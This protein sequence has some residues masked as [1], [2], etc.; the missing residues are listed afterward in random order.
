M[1]TW[2][3]AFAWL[4]AAW[5]VA[6]VL[7]TLAG[8]STPDPYGGAAALIMVILFGLPGMLILGIAWFVMRVRSRR[9]C[10]LCSQDLK[11][12]VA[13]CKKC[14]F[15]FGRDIIV[16]AGATLP[17]TSPHDRPSPPPPLPPPTLG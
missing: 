9:R 2:R 12:G 15:R 4:F 1:R 6:T 10:P 5:T 3:K 13:V 7:L 11:D 14:G 8:L 16:G 17:S